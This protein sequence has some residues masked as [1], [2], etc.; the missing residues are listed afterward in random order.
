MIRPYDVGRARGAMLA[1]LA[2]S[3]AVFVVDDWRLLAPLCLIQPLI[4]LALG[5]SV[6]R[7]LRKLA[8]FAVLVVGSYAVFGTGAENP[9]SWTLPGLQWQLSVDGLIYGVTMMLRVF[10]VVYASGWVRLVAGPR[11]FAGGLVSLG[12]PQSYASLL[13]G[14]LGMVE[15]NPSLRGGGG[16]GRGRGRGR[17]SGRGNGK[18]RGHA[19]IEIRHLARGDTGVFVDLVERQ[20]RRAARRA[21][22]R[23]STDFTLLS[24][25]LALMLGIKALKIV[26]GLPFAP[27]HKGV[28]LIP[29][30][31]LAAALTHR[32][33]GATL[34]GSTFGT[35][36]FLFG[37]GKYGI[38]E[39][40]KHI[41]PGVLADAFAPILRRSRS[42]LM[43]AG[44][45]MVL[46][47]GRWGTIALVVLLV[48]APATVVALLAPVALVHL[49]F[50]AASGV[51][52][53][54]L[55]R[56][57]DRIRSAA[58]SMD[59]RADGEQQRDAEEYG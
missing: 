45:G 22:G 20:V 53:A 41:T 27:G 59:A 50:G 24:G 3:V 18:G 35:A 52:T 25:L 40:F 28:V 54:A 51:V 5:G 16:G 23:E 39:I 30:Y 37:D 38:F 17:G 14:T 7:T 58:E 49:G 56:G 47:A 44:V 32:R 46:A 29:T 31:L 43:Y 55:I 9:R 6:T 42:P 19:P 10:T 57:G 13:D 26:P 12:F 8:P 21:D 33:N 15:S 34:L 1:L 2:L 36:S 48:G 4:V 11:G